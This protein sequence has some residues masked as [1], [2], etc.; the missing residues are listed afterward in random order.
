MMDVHPVVVLD[1][2]ADKNGEGDGLA[3]NPIQ[4]LDG[5]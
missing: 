1:E 4:T 2:H 5:R 3:E